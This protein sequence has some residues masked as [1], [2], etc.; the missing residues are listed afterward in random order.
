MIYDNLNKKVAR[1]RDYQFIV[2]FI[3]GAKPPET[4]TTDPVRAFKKSTLA[5]AAYTCFQGVSV[6]PK[7]IPT[8]VEPINGGIKEADT[9]IEFPT[10]DDVL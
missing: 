7:S 1:I 9:E 10:V 3:N 6:A 5:E 2:T 4:I 8:P